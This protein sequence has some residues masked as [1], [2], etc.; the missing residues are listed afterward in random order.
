MTSTN[1]SSKSMTSLLLVAIAT[2]SVALAGCAST[3]QQPSD[4]EL[5]TRHEK[6]VERAET[7]RADYPIGSR[8]FE[9]DGPVR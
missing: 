1:A 9:T 6:M 7:L 3:P 5:Q 2:A 4:P 8:A